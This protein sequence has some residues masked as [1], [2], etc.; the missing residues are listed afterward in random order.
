[1]L[2]NFKTKK[3][4]SS[5]IALIILLAIIICSTAQ[6]QANDT[7]SKLQLANT[8]V[9]Q[10]FNEVLSAEKAGANVTSLLNQLNVAS[11]LLAQAENAYRTGNSS[12]AANSAE[13]V[14][15]IAQ[16]V[17]TAA[18]NAKEKATASAAQT[19]VLLTIV[20]T[21]SGAVAFILLLFIAW[22]WLKRK[23]IKTFSKTKPVATKQ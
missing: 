20:F 17:A 3:T 2:K 4:V 15:P 11:G 22:R 9:E 16:Q 18:E 6:A 23:Y 19:S 8:A 1:M 14:L 21:V 7:T 10:A 5:L 12:T 13:A